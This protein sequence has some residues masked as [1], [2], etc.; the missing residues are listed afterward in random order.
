MRAGTRQRV[1]QVQLT[2]S[3]ANKSVGAFTRTAKRSVDTV[4]KDNDDVVP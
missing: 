2:V 3:R 1:A 4:E